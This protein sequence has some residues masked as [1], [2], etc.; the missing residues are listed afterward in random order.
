MTAGDYRAG[1]G[2]AVVALALWPIIFSGVAG[3]LICFRPGRHPVKRIVWLVFVPAALGLTL[4]VSQLVALGHAHASVLE[5]AGQATGGAGWLHGIPWKAMTG[6]HFCLAGLLLIGIYTSRLAFGIAQLPLSLPNSPSAGPGD[7]E[8]WS[9]LKFLIWILVGPLFLLYSLFL[10]AI[11]FLPAMLTSHFPFYTH[12]EW[13]SQMSFAL[14]AL[15]VFAI[16]LW[17]MGEENRQVV[18]S[19]AR[20][21]EPR[22]VALGLAFPV[23]IAVLFSTGQYLLDRA[24]WAARDFGKGFPPQ[25]GS[26]FG[27]PDP[28][29][30]L[31]FFPALF[32][33]LIFRGLLQRR[34]VQRYG[35]YRGIFMVGIVWAAFHFFSDFSFSRLTETD[36][37]LRLGSRLFTCLTLSYVFG[38]L[39]LRFG[40]ILPAAVA[41]AFYNV[42]V[43]SGFGPPFLG[44]E[45]VVVALWAVLALV[46]FRYWPVQMKDDPEAAASV[47]NPEPAM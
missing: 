28:W 24:I 15:F 23:A 44:K 47:A 17:I 33:E 26:Y 11:L 45:T 10:F 32:E 20:L 29:P 22:Y 43:Y 25:F 9:G 37:L 14:G 13:F 5:I 8:K 30:L 39:T 12:G 27:F 3:Y 2:R 41:H 4:I 40:S 35:V 46:L 18:W 7:E 42:L 1:L 31:L 19:S 34:F 21:P 6:F 38:W 36:A 16:L